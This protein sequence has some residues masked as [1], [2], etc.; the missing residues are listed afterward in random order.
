M[1]VSVSACVAGW[2]ANLLEVGY[3]VKS[4]DHSLSPA[5]HRIYSSPS[6]KE[7]SKAARMT[8]AFHTCPPHAVWS[9]D[10]CLYVLPV[11]VVYI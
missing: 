2:C 4:N 6:T 5:S 8:G 10:V 3:I 9:C 1:P 11:N 7:Q